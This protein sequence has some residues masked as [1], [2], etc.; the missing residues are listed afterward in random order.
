MKSNGLSVPT[1]PSVPC[2][3]HPNTHV[4]NCL[5]LLHLV[6][7]SIAGRAV[8]QQIAKSNSAAGLRYPLPNLANLVRDQSRRCW[9]Q[10]RRTRGFRTSTD[11]VDWVTARLTPW[12][13]FKAWHTLFGGD[14]RPALAH[15][16]P[17]MQ[18]CVRRP[19]FTGGT[20]NRSSA[21]YQDVLAWLAM[22]EQTVVVSDRR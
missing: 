16:V 11:H 12:P 21:G 22:F 9:R 5:L 10:Q 15:G 18:T 20:G 2:T 6:G 1:L 4:A 17:P 14:R 8:D 13:N 19:P 7:P 3:I